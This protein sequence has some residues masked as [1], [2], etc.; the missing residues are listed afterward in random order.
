MC[1]GSSICWV[2][3]RLS[4]VRFINR[5]APFVVCRLPFNPSVYSAV[6][7]GGCY[8]SR[9]A[10]WMSVVL[11]CVVCQQSNIRKKLLLL[12]WWNYVFTKYCIAIRCRTQA[13]QTDKLEA[14]VCKLRERLGELG[15]LRSRVNELRT[16]NHLL[17]EAKQELEEQLAT[18]DRDMSS[19]AEIGKELMR[20]KQLLQQSTEVW[21]TCVLKSTGSSYCFCCCWWWWWWQLNDFLS[22][23]RLC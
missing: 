22:L 4:Q 14:E 9:P 16:E 11:D 23:S 8:V 10:L 18:R 12:F 19:L 7:G 5:W 3:T 20:Y 13:S 17:L 21:E 6:L 15:F 2:L 1:A